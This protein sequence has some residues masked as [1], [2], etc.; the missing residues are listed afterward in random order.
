MLQEGL[1]VDVQS[2]LE[3]TVV[4]PK[5]AFSKADERPTCVTHY[6]S[7]AVKK[8]LGTP[9]A[10]LLVDDVVTAGRMLLSSVSKLK[11]AYPQTDVRAFALI[12]TMSGV[13]IQSVISPCVGKI[14]LC[15]DG[16]RSYRQP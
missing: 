3:R 12:R 9:K 11:D 16:E 13:E 2:L 5:A 4:V 15:R 8:Q 7:L 6:S 14:I 10:I 1:G